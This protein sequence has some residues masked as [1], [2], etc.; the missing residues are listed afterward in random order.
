MEN[1]EFVNKITIAIAVVMF[2]ILV[3]CIVY[4]SRLDSSNCTFMENKYSLNGYIIPIS[5]DSAYN[6]YDY[7]I[8]TAFNACSGGSLKNDFVNIRNLKSIIRQGVRCLDFEIYSIDGRPVIATSTS[9]EFYYKETF[10]HVTF[11][12]VLTTIEKYAFAPEQ[13]NN[14]TDPLLLHLRIKSNDSNMINV[15]ATQIAGCERMLGNEFSYKDKNVGKTPIL[16]FRNKIILILDTSHDENDTLNEYTNLISNSEHM[17]LYRYYD[18]KNTPD[19]N[20]LIDYNKT[21]LSIVLPDKDGANPSNPSGVLAREMGCHMVA[22]R[23]QYVDGYL[24]ENES[25]FNNSQSAFVLKPENMRYIAVYTKELPPQ[26]PKLSYATRNV[27]T[28]FY[29]FDF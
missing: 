4:F 3:I 16:Q 6:L 10:N 18:V 23:Y 20:E 22:M 8:K 26:D 29:S 11:A 24:T 27:T 21:G 9:D 17:R 7:Y 19:M 25:F 13:S 14:Y 28:D 15:L 5:T 12:D 1:E 2:I